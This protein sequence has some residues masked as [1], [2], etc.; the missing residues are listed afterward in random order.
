MTSCQ[1]SAALRSRTDTKA[2]SHCC[3]ATNLWKVGSQVCTVPKEYTTKLS[4]YMYD[5]MIILKTT[6]LYYNT[7]TCYFF[8]IAVDR[9]KQII[10]QRLKS[11]ANAE[12]EHWQGHPERRNPAASSSSLRTWKDWPFESEILYLV[13]ASLMANSEMRSTRKSGKVST[14]WCS[15][16]E[17]TSGF[18]VLVCFTNLSAAV[19]QTKTQGN[20]TKGKSI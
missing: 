20:R 13:S 4:T 3:D 12:D 19:E 1:R 14:G 5:T 8:H 15:A 17:S 10:C 18:P 7:N 6:I 16:T 11:T 2:R 9:H